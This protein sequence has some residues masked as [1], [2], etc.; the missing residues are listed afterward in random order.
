MPHAGPACCRVGD[1]ASTKTAMSTLQ[2][3][4]AIHNLSV[5]RWIPSPHPVRCR[6]RGLRRFPGDVGHDPGEDAPVPANPNAAAFSSV[7]GTSIHI[8]C[9]A[10][11]WPIAENLCHQ[12]I[13]MNH[14]TSAVASLDPEMVQVGDAVG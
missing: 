5:S 10:Q 13:F 6:R 7:S 12:A 9:A 2:F 8:P 3:R 11:P 1:L 14:A 4:K